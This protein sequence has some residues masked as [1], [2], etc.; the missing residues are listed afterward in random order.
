MQC[1]RNDSGWNHQSDSLQRD[2][3]GGSHGNWG[4]ANLQAVGTLFMEFDKPIH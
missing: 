3:H 1:Q 2:Q 4:D